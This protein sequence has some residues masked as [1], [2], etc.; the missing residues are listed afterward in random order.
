MKLQEIL[1]SYTAE[2]LKKLVRVPGGPGPD[3]TRK[4]HLV[5][6]LVERLTRPDSLAELWERLDSLSQKAVAAAYHAGGELN[7]EAFA[8]QYGE[9]PVRR[10]DDLI[11][12]FGYEIEVVYGYEPLPLDLFIHRGEL[13]EELMALLEPLVPPPDRFRLEGLE[14]VPEA[15]EIDGETF[16]LLRADTEQAGLHDLMAY[17]Q[18]YEQGELRYGTAS[19][20]LTPTGIRT[21]LDNLLEGDFM[22]HGENARPKDAIRPF[23]LDVF[24]QGSGLVGNHYRRTL[25]EGGEALLLQQDFEALLEAF[26]T[27]TNEGSFDE[28]DRIPTVKGKK[29]KSTSLSPPASRREAIVEG[30]SWCPVGVWIHVADF[31][32]AL[33]VWHLDFEVDL[34]YDGNLSIEDYL[35][36]RIYYV[37]EEGRALIKG[38]YTNAVLM[39]YLGSI[40]ALDLLY[41]PPEETVPY[42]DLRDAHYSPYDGLLY[43]RINPLGAYLLGQAGEYASPQPFDAP[44]FNIDPELVLTLKEPD[45]LTPN[46]LHQLHQLAVEQKPGRYR[47]D[48][49]QVLNTLESGGDLEH[50]TGFLNRRHE[51]LLPAQVTDWLAEIEDHGS[52]FQHNGDALFVKARSQELLRLVAEDPVLGKFSKTLEARTLIIPSSK[53][54][55]FR[56]RLKELGYLLAGR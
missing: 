35:Y 51:G 5:S 16:P 49:R 37:E 30:L 28:L 18:V 41:L 42:P 53:E 14:R 7:E 45:V 55:T 10:G 44:L 33:K 52:A 22:P 23:G 25:S 15:V 50:I 12:G 6:Y 21:L 3:G 56:K 11:Y 46:L 34:S 29:A 17:L 13:P 19:A 40:G 48:T 9:L 38:L 32:R 4:E 27:W 54:K 20:R 1:Q 26:E 8:A 47:L 31:Y 2:Q 43:F 39:E 36:G 24:V